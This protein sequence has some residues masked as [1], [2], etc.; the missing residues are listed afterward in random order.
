VNIQE[1]KWE[2]MKE[3]AELEINLRKKVSEKCMKEYV[4]LRTDRT[5]P[6]LAS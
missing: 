5:N 4:N 6:E 2:R 1:G 3:T